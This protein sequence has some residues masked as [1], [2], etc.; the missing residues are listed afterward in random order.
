MIE[1]RVSWV[2]KAL[3]VNCSFQRDKLFAAPTV[4]SV[5]QDLLC[6]FEYFETRTDKDEF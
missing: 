5:K 3:V 1:W 2:V 6:Q 4:F